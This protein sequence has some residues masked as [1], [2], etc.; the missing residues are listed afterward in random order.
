MGLVKIP[1]VSLD[2]AAT[3]YGRIRVL[4]DF[5]LRDSVCEADD[6]VCYAPDNIVWILRTLLNKHRILCVKYQH[7]C[8]VSSP[9]NESEKR[10]S[11]DVDGRALSIRFCKV[12]RVIK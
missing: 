7:P 12:I 9:I 10:S 5:C 1:V 2:P 11:I 6:H 8:Y 3:L 4:C